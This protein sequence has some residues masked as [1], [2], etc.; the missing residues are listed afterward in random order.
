VEHHI[1]QQWIDVVISP[2]SRE[3]IAQWLDWHG[4]FVVMMLVSGSALVFVVVASLSSGLPRAVVATARGQAAIVA[5]LG[6]WA[7]APGQRTGWMTVADL[8]RCVG[9]SDTHDPQFEADVQ[10]LY[11][12]GTIALTAS[13]PT[14]SR[15]FAEAMLV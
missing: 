5:A 10:A 12:A 9:A 15:H 4:L 2:A 1:V 13:G 7:G 11:D 8:A 14:A 3:A 6:A